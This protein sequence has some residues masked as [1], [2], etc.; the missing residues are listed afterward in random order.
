V[1]GLKRGR[2]G[3]LLAALAAFGLLAVVSASWLAPARAVTN[4]PVADSTIDGEEQAFVNLLNNYRIANGLQPLTISA[5]LNRAASWM[6]A[7]MANG[8]Y[9]P[10]DHKDSLGRTAQ[11]RAADCGYPWGVW[12]N[13][14][15][16]SSSASAVFD[17]WA[18]SDGHRA[19]MLEPTLKQAG[20]ARAYNAS[21]RYGWYWV[22]NFGAVD[23]G[24]RAGAPPPPPPPPTPTPA[25]PAPTPIPP[26]P[27]A[28]TPIPP[29]PPAPTPIPP[30]PTP[31]PVSVTLKPGANLIT[32]GGR[33]TTPADAVSGAAG[34]ITV[35]YGY[36]A[37]TASW[38][39]YGPGAPGYVND[40]A[41][42]K[43]GG[44]YW[45]MAEGTFELRFPN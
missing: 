30:T 42:L 5:N 20:V 38:Q 2:S 31:V 44:V 24:T 7:D 11:I 15:A 8:N 6:A 1:D 26:T 17:A 28:P 34:T 40:L 9:F 22:A 33:D 27:P 19:N 32:W 3:A 36:H 35:I 14:Y 21:S 4:C 25:P 43:R 39:K 41:L 45:F 12:E 16:G 18:A 10:P 13:L 37:A 29:T 23:D